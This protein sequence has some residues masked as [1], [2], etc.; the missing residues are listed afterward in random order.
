M[1][2]GVRPGRGAA[3]VSGAPLAVWLPGPTPGAEKPRRGPVGAAA[4][5]GA[6]GGQAPA[7]APWWLR[8]ARG[9]HCGGG[10]DRAGPTS[11]GSQVAAR[12]LSLSQDSVPSGGKHDAK[13]CTHERAL[14]GLEGLKQAR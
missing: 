9:G 2:G 12:L 11:P 4:R 14:V 1:G 8:L 6:G 7:A 3:C 5:A 13:G 10:G